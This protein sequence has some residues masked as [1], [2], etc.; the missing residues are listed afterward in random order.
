[1]FYMHGIFYL[2]ASD[3]TKSSHEHRVTVILH[4]TVFNTDRTKM[5]EKYNVVIKE[6]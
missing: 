4:G 6:L 3:K 1:M 5:A 2:H